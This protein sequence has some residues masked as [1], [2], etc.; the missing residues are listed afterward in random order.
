MC[1][2]TQPQP[3]R[4]THRKL[5][6]S[7]RCAEIISRPARQRH[8]SSGCSHGHRRSAGSRVAQIDPSNC[9]SRPGLG[10]DRAAARRLVRVV[11]CSPGAGRSLD[12]NSRADCV[13]D[14][15]RSYVL[16]RA[17]REC[18]REE[19]GIR[20]TP[21]VARLQFREIRQD[22][23]S[24]PATRFM[25]LH[26]RLH[27]RQHWRGLVAINRRRTCLRTSRRDLCLVLREQAGRAK[28]GEGRT[29]GELRRAVQTKSLARQ[30]A[31][32]P[33]PLQPT[34]HIHP[35]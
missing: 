27:S 35:A 8:R 6:Q 16:A 3:L 10:D 7:E 2:L 4:V 29:A 33:S 25:R 12:H 1:E 21:A 17:S 22:C 28:Q 18:S 5:Q 23:A 14:N 30:Q 13:V 11:S 9:R 15:P 34:P 24:L 26:R 32:P 31:V 20:E 19:S